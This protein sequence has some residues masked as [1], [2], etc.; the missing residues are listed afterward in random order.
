[1]ARRRHRRA[2]L[3]G[4]AGLAV[5]SSAPSKDA[6]KVVGAFVLGKGRQGAC[7]V[8]KKGEKRSES[9]CNYRTDGL[10]LFVKGSTVAS[11]MPLGITAKSVKVCPAELQANDQEATK[12]AGALF[13][14][15]GTGISLQTRNGK[16]FLRGRRPIGRIEAPSGC[17]T[18]EVSKQI[19][20]AAQRALKADV[21][22]GM[23]KSARSEENVARREREAEFEAAHEK[24]LVRFQKSRQTKA[25][26][27]RL[28]DRRLARN[29]AA[30]GTYLKKLKA[31]LKRLKAPA[32]GLKAKKSRKGRRK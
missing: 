20:T 23:A 26:I 12:A 6:L 1:M 17:F 5:R 9:D 2:S 8:P 13:S 29:E 24:R 19:R 3:G 14:V 28:D 30:S 31:R 11:K 21:A 15:L 25:A 18:V 10:E 22:K 27:R 4:L 32:K 7:R 16:R